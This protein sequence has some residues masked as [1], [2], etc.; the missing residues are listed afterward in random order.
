LNTKLTVFALLLA[1]PVALSARPPGVPHYI[2]KDLGTFGGPNSVIG[3]TPPLNSSG[4]VVGQADTTESSPTLGGPIS[5][6]FMWNKGY[7]TDLG[8]LPEGDDFSFALEINSSGTIAGISSDGTPDPIFGEALFIGTVWKNGRITRLASLG[9]TYSVPEGLN[10]LGQ[11]AGGAA[12]TI[13]DPDYKWS[14]SLYSTVKDI[15]SATMWHA[16][17]WQNGTIRDLG[18][19]GGP[20]SYAYFIDGGGQVAGVS[21]IRPQQPVQPP[22]TPLW[23]D[24]VPLIHPFFWEN[25]RMTDIGTLGGVFAFADAMNSVGQVVGRSDLRG[26]EAMHAF[27]WSK[28]KMID[29][30][31]I[32]DAISAPSSINDLGAVVGFL[33]GADR[34]GGFLWRD[35]V[36]TDLG[37]LPGLT[38]TFPHSI[39]NKGQVV[40]DAD[41]CNFGVGGT[42]WLWQDGVGFVDLNALLPPGTDMHLLEANFIDD[43]GE[44]VG[45]GLLPNGDA[46]VFVLIPQGS[47]SDSE[48]ATSGAVAARDAQ[49]PYAAPVNL[50]P[51]MQAELRARVENRG[52]G[53]GTR[54]TR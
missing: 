48:A 29:L 39:N 34:I 47:S 35:G 16:A 30:G 49:A 31:T 20:A 25:G 22:G 40:G 17:L 28:G 51:E 23:P 6:A 12:T 13:P 42:V 44:I 33:V 21:Y 10:D 11:M 15:P 2:L 5:H 14:G 32:G 54:L 27:R 43:R 24:G 37:T 53:W 26:D 50:S 19:L 1:L 18:T 7:L 41:N 4:T 36:M 45:E 9:G 38:C 8:T 3:G 46:H 52:H